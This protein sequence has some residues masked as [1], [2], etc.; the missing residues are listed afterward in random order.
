MVLI[1][2]VSNTCVCP[3]DL[4]SANNAAITRPPM[5]IMPLSQDHQPTT[6]VMIIYPTNSKS[7]F[8]ENK[9]V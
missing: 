5:Q 3:G 7:R 1:M 2:L 9:F 4:I 6:N 8:H